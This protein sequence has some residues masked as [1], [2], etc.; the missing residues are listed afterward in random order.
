MVMRKD[1]AMIILLLA[2]ILIAMLWPGFLRTVFFVIAVGLAIGWFSIGD[3]VSEKGVSTVNEPGPH[4]VDWDKRDR[5]RW[6][7]GS[8]R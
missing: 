2:L 7:D 6:L 4:G 3:R 8:R 5:A 1:G